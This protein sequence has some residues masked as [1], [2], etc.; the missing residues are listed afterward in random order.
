MFGPEG[1]HPWKTKPGGSRLDA[2]ME[3]IRNDEKSGRHHSISRT[4]DLTIGGGE[5]VDQQT[6]LNEQAFKQFD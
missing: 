4:G 6:E 3:A 2:E 5:K 1:L